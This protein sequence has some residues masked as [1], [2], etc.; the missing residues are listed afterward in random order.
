M[1]AW[2]TPSPRDRDFLVL[3]V[4]DRILAGGRTARL[5]KAL[6]YSKPPHLS[7][8]YAYLLP[9]RYPYMYVWGAVIEPGMSV[10]YLQ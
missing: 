1:W 6:V 10:V 5:Q 8:L 4:L 2:P 9:M 3:E 7:R